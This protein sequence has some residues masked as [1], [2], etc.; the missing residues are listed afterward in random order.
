MP[1]LEAISLTISAFVIIIF[2]IYYISE[3]GVQTYY[4]L[5]ISHLYSFYLLIK[6]LALILKRHSSKSQIKSLLE[7]IL[8]SKGKTD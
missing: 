3:L 2:L 5:S 1:V 7:H 6:Y 4:I 8:F